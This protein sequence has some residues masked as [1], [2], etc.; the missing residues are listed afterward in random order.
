MNGDEICQISRSR[1]LYCLAL[2]IM[3]S[4]GKKFNPHF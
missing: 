4:I 3:A 2:N 1:L